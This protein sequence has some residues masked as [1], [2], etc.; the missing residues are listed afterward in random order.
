[1]KN[2]ELILHVRG[3]PCCIYIQEMEREK[4]RLNELQAVAERMLPLAK[5]SQ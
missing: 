2:S 4:P 1:M 3:L 5:L